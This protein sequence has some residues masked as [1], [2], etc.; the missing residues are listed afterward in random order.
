MK[1]TALFLIL[2]VSLC[3]QETFH[4]EFSNLQS[5]AGT[6][7]N[8]VTNYKNN[9]YLFQDEK[10]SF[11]VEHDPDSEI[12]TKNSFLQIYSSKTLEYTLEKY[13][14]I[15]N[16]KHLYIK[17]FNSL[18]F[19]RLSN[20]SPKHTR[21]MFIELQEKFPDIYYSQAAKKSTKKILTIDKTKHKIVF[22]DDKKAKMKSNLLKDIVFSVSPKDKLASLKMKKIYRKGNLDKVYDLKDYIANFSV[23]RGD[24]LGASNAGLYGFEAFTNYGLLCSNS[25]EILYL[26]SKED[27]KSIYDLRRKKISV[28]NISD[29]SQVYLKD[30]ANDSGVMLDINFKSFDLKD[31]MQKIRQGEIDAFFMF[32]P[33]NKVATILKN[34]LHISS[35]PND[36]LKVLNDKQGLNTLKYKI[37]GR[38]IRSYK[39]PN[40]VVGLV[41]TLD[42]EMPKK[43][44][45]VV[46]AFG[47]YKQ[48]KIPDAFYGNPHPELMNIMAAIKAEAAAVAAKEKLLN[49]QNT[50][51]SIKFYKEEK[52]KK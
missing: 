36:F 28:G 8:V 18:Y 34:K 15:K 43:V 13:K 19:L 31:S 30:I 1:I 52:L 9:V 11:H 40:Y 46:E 37:D 4:K 3:S 39:V 33:K 38:L 49:E 7:Q 2:V 41:E 14:A 24:V 21:N 6:F 16:K 27:I 51:L 48:A 44:R 23:I 32:A 35:T 20:K 25:E 50:A 12:E 47:C 10:E 5:A 29:I 22:L 45:A 17:K 26:V 42:A